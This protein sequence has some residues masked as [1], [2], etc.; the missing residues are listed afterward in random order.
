MRILKI[1]K[2]I[3]KIILGLLIITAL[4]VILS[5]IDPDAKSWWLHW[6]CNIWIIYCYIEHLIT[7][8]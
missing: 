2:T 7:D 1:I 5:D 8:K 4:S 3:L 6:S